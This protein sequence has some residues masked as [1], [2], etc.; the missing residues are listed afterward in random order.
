MLSE[1]T[2]S[3]TFASVVVTA[4]IGPHG[5]L[6]YRIPEAHQTSLKPGMRVLVPIGTRKM[7][8]IRSLESASLRMQ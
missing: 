7:T 8:G 2:S 4:P 6:T 1:K 3:F 5:E